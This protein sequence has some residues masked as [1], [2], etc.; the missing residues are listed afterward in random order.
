MSLARPTC[1]RIMYCLIILFQGVEVAI[2]PLAVRTVII[3]FHLSLLQ[4]PGRPP[5]PVFPLRRLQGHLQLLFFRHQAD[6]GQRRC[7][8]PRDIVVYVF[9]LE[10]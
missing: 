7:Y 3:L 5:T 6:I 4:T 2:S 1:D 10:L 9:V 8:R